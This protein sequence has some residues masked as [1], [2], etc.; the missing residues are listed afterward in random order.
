[1]GQMGGTLKR[2]R[3]NPSHTQGSIV[4]K[5]KWKLTLSYGIF[6]SYVM[7]ASVFSG[8]NG[9]ITLVEEVQGRGDNMAK[10][11]AVPKVM[12]VDIQ[13]AVKMKLWSTQ[14]RRMSIES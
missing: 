12:E 13:E 7:N 10:G 6:C 2:R 3:V 14:Q 4:K 5:Q 11:S 1:M 8:H 9:Q